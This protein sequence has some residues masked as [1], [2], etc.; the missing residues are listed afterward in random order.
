MDAH[1][2]GSYTPRHQTTTFPPSDTRVTGSARLSVSAL[3]QLASCPRDRYSA[4]ATYLVSRY[5]PIPSNPPSR[6]N[7]DCLTP[8]NGAAGL[9]TIPW[10]RPTMPVSIPSHTRSARVKSRV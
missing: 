4:T 9:E 6:P 10:L 1:G 8:P 7:P 5:S 3:T 2:A